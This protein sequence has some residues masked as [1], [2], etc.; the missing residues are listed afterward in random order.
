MTEWFAILDATTLPGYPDA[1]ATLPARDGVGRRLGH[2]GRTR[3]GAD[4]AGSILESIQTLHGRIDYVLHPKKR[5]T[6]GGPFN[7]QVG[8]RA[9]FDALCRALTPAAIV[10]TGTHRGTTTEYFATLGPP[11]YT[12]EFNPK[13]FGFA[14]QRLGGRASITLIRGDSRTEMRRLFAGPLVAL[15]DRPIL[16][17][18]DA[19]WGED[20][21]LLE[22]VGLIYDF[23]R[24]AVIMI[25]DFKVPGDSDYNY[26]DYGPG[27]VLELDYLMPAVERH[28]LAAFAPALPAKEE[29]GMRR[30]SLVLCA[31]NEF[32]ALL[33]SAPIDAHLRQVH[34]RAG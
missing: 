20:L 21:P 24:K 31:D 17:Y 33:C 25:D 28:G 22:E 34:P 15:G 23:S 1:S 32:G 13:Y 3:T 18:L 5:N 27:K 26:D 19:H 12:I 6:W 9:I 11:I 10:E 4:V 16:F 2:G 14:S 29:T 7:G 8:R 30:G